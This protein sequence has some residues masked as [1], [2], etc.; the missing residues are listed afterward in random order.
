MIYLNSPT[1]LRS[2]CTVWILMSDYPPSP[3]PH[4]ALNIIFNFHDLPAL[5]LMGFSFFN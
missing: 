2:F 3:F 1:S 4:N 5:S